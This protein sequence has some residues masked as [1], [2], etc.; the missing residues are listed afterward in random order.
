LHEIEDKRQGRI[1]I[2][3]TDI[4]DL[5]AKL[6]KFIRRKAQLLG[7]DHYIESHFNAEQRRPLYVLLADLEENIQWK[8]PWWRAMEAVSRHIEQFARPISPV[9]QPPPTLSL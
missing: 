5:R 8:F 1:P 3:G 9:R 4:E 2:N 7:D 6:L